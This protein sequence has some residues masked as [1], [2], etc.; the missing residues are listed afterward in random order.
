MFQPTK[1]FRKWHADPPPDFPR[2]ARWRPSEK[3][4]WRWVRS[5]LGCRIFDGIQMDP[6]KKTELLV[7]SR[8]FSWWMYLILPKITTSGGRINGSIQSHWQNQHVLLVEKDLHE[9]C[10]SRKCPPPVGKILP[11]WLNLIQNPGWIG[12]CLKLGGSP[13]SSKLLVVFL[14]FWGTLMYTY[15]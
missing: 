12:S 13:N 6:T 4:R 11:V 5:W 14:W 15:C 10:K 7:E 1:S 2:N 3:S 8:S 9:M